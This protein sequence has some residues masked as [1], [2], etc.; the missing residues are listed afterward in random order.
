MASEK[1]SLNALPSALRDVL[2]RAAV[3]GDFLRDLVL[4]RDRAVFLPLTNHERKI[5]RSVPRN[6]L[7]TMVEALS[8]KE[9]KMRL[10]PTTL[11]ELERRPRLVITTRAG[12]AAPDLH[13]PFRNRR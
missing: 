2:A 10:D 1:D 3:N 11:T 12:G 6:Q 9:I 5:L 8:E 7:I 13:P 4:L